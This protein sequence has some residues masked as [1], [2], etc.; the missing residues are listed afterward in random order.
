MS[1]IRADSIKNR[2]GDGAPDFPN[3]ITV[4]GVVTATS[5]NQNVTGVSTFN[6]NIDLNGDLD[7]DGHT[8]LDNV[9]VAGVV[10][11]TTFIGA[12][13]GNPTGTLQTAAQPNITSVGTLSALNVSGNATVGGTL[14]IGGT[15]TYEDVTN[16]DSVGIVT[17]RLGL[18]VPDNVY[19]YFGTGNDLSIRHD[20]S[21]GNHSYIFN[22]GAGVFKLG[23][24]NQFLIG[25]TSNATYIQA[26]PD[27]DVKLYYNNNQKLATS[28]TG[29]TVTGTVAAT[30]YTGDGSNLTGIDATKIQ[31]GN[32]KVETSAS[33]IS[34]IIGNAGIATITAQ[35]LNVT[36][37]VTATSMK[38]FS[39]G[40]DYE[41]Q[42]GTAM[43]WWKSE[44]IVSTSSWPAAKG[45]SDANLVA[46]ATS[47]LSYISSEA[48]FNNNK[49]LRQS[50]NNTGGLH[51]TNDT[52]GYWWN[53]TDAFT[54]IMAIQ[55]DAHSSGSSYGDSYFV[56]NTNAV[57]GSAN[58]SWSIGP[59][60]DHTWGGEYGEMWGG[61]QNY[62]EGLE[63]RFS[64][65]WRGLYMVR[66][67]SSF[68]YGEISV[69]GGSGWQRIDM[70]HA[71]PSSLG[72]SWRA[73]SIFTNS[74][75]N[76]GHTAQGR[77]AE[78]AYFRNKRLG[79]NELDAITKSWCNKFNF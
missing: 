39:S 36:G 74:A 72:T 62:F 31:T 59:F 45:G 65:P 46:H 78:W 52:V 33:S 38:V 60:G 28:N 77:I 12:L 51:T 40:I 34:N 30:S 6:G 35:G 63:Q 73:L 50:G 13:T 44:D 20:A 26:N 19:S 43:A 27:G 76:S 16:V 49:C 10:T 56:Q 2:A 17:A 55:K 15:L 68:D 23:S 32:T 42:G 53:G 4:T 79:G 67:N 24:D 64:Y 25:K 3:G 29:V 70:R 7:V 37:I 66:M 71:G 22:N 11:A 47:G 54:A 21:G 8:N 9:S 5:L 18:R 48:A 61:L 41:W 69:N 58:H 57:G 1:I 14:G 75:S